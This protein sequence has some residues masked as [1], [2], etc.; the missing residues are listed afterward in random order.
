MAW[1]GKPSAKQL[2]QLLETKPKLLQLFAVP[3]FLQELKSYNPKLLEYITNTPSLIHE[4]IQLIIVPP[5]ANDSNDR[6][7]KHPLQ[8]VEMV[9]A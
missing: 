8:A 4:A 6:K 1:Y 5:S 3:D 7:Y 9:E 2:E